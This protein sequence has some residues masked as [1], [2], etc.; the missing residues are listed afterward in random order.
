MQVQFHRGT[1]AQNDSYTGPAGELTVDTENNHIRVHDGSTK[2]G[3]S[4]PNTDSLLATM[5]SNSDRITAVSNSKPLLEDAPAITHNNIYRGDNLLDGHFASV[6]DIFKAVRAG[7]FSDIYIGDYIK[8]QNTDLEGFLC[9]THFDAIELPF[10]S[11]ARLEDYIAVVAGINTGGYPYTADNKAV[12]NYLCFFMYAP[13]GA[14][15]SLFGAETVEDSSTKFHFQSLFATNCIPYLHADPYGTT[16]SLRECLYSEEG[17]ATP[18]NL[19]YFFNVDISNYLLYT[20]EYL[21]SS[22]TVS[23]SATVVDWYTYTTG[24]RFEIPSS[25]EIL[26][27]PSFYNKGSDII[28]NSGNQ[29][30]LFKFTDKWL[31]TDL[32][33]WVRDSYGDS[34]STLNSAVTSTTDATTG[35]RSLQLTSVEKY[36][37]ADEYSAADYPKAKN[38]FPRF[39]VG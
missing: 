31:A 4:I 27:R 7:D 18:R 35:K 8:P 33:M 6:E 32:D 10:T 14:T 22:L 24:C 34:P 29:L 5:K 39:F 19:S 11:L 16:T 21:Q 20:N 12:S 37:K 26:G 36:E 2:G 25:V 15:K 30:P 3:H 13:D 17:S 38:V 28:L 23:D 1:T 9:I